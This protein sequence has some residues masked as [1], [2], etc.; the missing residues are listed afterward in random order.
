V[1]AKSRDAALCAAR[2]RSK[3]V[4]KTFDPTVSGHNFGHGRRL[5]AAQ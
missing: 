1:E 4:E 2:G 5:A 3:S